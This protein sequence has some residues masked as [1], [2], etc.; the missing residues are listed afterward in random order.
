M[1]LLIKYEDVLYQLSSEE[2]I[3][4]FEFTEIDVIDYI[5]NNFP[6]FIHNEITGYYNNHNQTLNEIT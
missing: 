4:N 5:K 3:L 1:R 6:N 2:E